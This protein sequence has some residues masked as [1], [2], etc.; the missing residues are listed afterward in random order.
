ME[1]DELDADEAVDEVEAVEEIE[2]VAPIE[3]IADPIATA[4]RRHGAAG[5]MVAAGMF[6]ID[7]IYNGRKVK[8]DAPIVV[9]ASSEPTDLDKDGITVPIDDNTDFVAPALPR[10]EPIDRNRRKGRRW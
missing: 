5:A 8:E 7:Q 2:E 9:D 3:P 10:T 6:A 4:R 1:P